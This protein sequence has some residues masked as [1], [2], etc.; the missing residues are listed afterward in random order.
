MKDC[1][2]KDGYKTNGRLE[3]QRE[4]IGNGQTGDLI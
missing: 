4:I 1:I 3:L 2:K